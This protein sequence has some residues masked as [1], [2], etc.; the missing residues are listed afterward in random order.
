MTMTTEGVETAPDNEAGDE[1]A[2]QAFYVRVDQ[3]YRLFEDWTGQKDDDDETARETE[4]SERRQSNG[5]AVIAPSD[6]LSTFAMFSARLAVD[7]EL[8]RGEFLRALG[9]MYD[10]ERDQEEDEELASAAVSGG[11]APS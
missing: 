10:N 9:T 6:A 5:A 3:L 11:S 4:P 7:F 2:Q 1:V 8:E